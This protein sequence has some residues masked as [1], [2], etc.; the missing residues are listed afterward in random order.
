MHN[1]NRCLILNCDYTPL[2]TIGWQKAMVLWYRSKLAHNKNIEIISFYDTDFI[3]GTYEKMPLP[4]IART[5]VYYNFFSKNTKFSRKNLF[6]RD[7]YTCQYCGTK[8][9]I[10]QLTYDHIIPKS[11]WP[12][13]SSKK[14]TNWNN[15]ITACIKC[16][17]KKA[18][19]TPQQANMP[20][21]TKPYVPVKTEKYLPI[22]QHLL[23][24]E[25]IP[26]E[27]LPYISNY[28]KN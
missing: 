19:K 3:N 12:K 11:M 21:L 13:N 27:W 28:I 15:I 14:C 16:N 5:K 22:T 20:L 4:C 24:I 6:I 7:N 8:K 26:E 1:H 10:K 2:C 23:T 9:E 17:A 25:Q 18:N